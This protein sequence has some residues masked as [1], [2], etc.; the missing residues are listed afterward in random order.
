MTFKAIDRLLIVERKSTGQKVT[1]A[2]NITDKPITALGIT[3]GAN[4]YKIIVE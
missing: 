4:D 3:V 1:L 2:V